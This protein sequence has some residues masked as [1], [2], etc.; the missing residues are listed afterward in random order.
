MRFRWKLVTGV[1]HPT[2]AGAWKTG[3]LKGCVLG[4]GGG[5]ET[6]PTTESNNCPGD[7]YT[8]SG[9]S[10]GLLG[11]PDDAALNKTHF[12]VSCSWLL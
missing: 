11:C 2:G 6:P 12:A 8:T 10:P 9:G 7:I 1:G 4:N 5:W 3:E